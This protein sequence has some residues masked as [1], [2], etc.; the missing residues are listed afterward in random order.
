MQTSKVFDE[1]IPDEVLAEI[2]KLEE[3]V[4]VK[5]V[6]CENNIKG[7]DSWLDQMVGDFLIE[8][9][10]FDIFDYIDPGLQSSLDEGVHHTL[11]RTDSEIKHPD[12]NLNSLS[13]RDE[14]TYQLTC[15]ACCELQNSLL[16]Q[17]EQNNKSIAELQ[18]EV[19]SIWASLRQFSMVEKPSISQDVAKEHSGSAEF[20]VAEAATVPTSAEEVSEERLPQCKVTSELSEDTLLNAERQEQSKDPECQDQAK[21]SGCYN[22]STELMSANLQ[23]YRRNIRIL[24]SKVKR[25]DAQGARRRKH[26]GC[27]VPT[28]EQCLK[29]NRHHS[30]DVQPIASMCK[31]QK[32]VFN[33]YCIQDIIHRVD[34]SERNDPSAVFSPENAMYLDYRI[35]SILNQISEFGRSEQNEENGFVPPY[36]IQDESLSSYD[37]A[38]RETS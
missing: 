19:R 35:F 26:D 7:D 3:D 18:N 14:D 20:C 5:E 37:Q 32:N 21:D 8:N 16:P 13:N 36:S 24:K 27:K 25:E 23:Q 9:P 10:S 4:R 31:A 28:C 15:R 22:S 33:F 12:A 38:T 11:E 29:E 30:H 6:P 2:E 1:G 17:L 34:A